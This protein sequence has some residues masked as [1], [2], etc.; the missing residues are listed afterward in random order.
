MYKIKYFKYKKKYIKLRDLYAGADDK[1]SLNPKALEWSPTTVINEKKGINTKALEWSPNTV[2]KE[3]LERAVEKLLDDQILDHMIMVKE[4]KHNDSNIFLVNL[5]IAQKDK[6][7]I[8]KTNENYKMIAYLRNFNNLHY[9][10]DMNV[11]LTA[12][13]KKRKCPFKGIP[14]V[15]TSLKH[16]GIRS[17]S[18]NKYSVILY[19]ESDND[20]KLRISNIISLLLTELKKIENTQVLICL[21]EINP[22]NLFNEVYNSLNTDGF[23][24]IYE[25]DENQGTQ[26]ILIYSN[27]Y[28]KIKSIELD[29]SS[30]SLIAKLKTG[31]K[32]F[33]NNKYT[34]EFNNEIPSIHLYNVHTKYYENMNAVNFVCTLPIDSN[35]II[36]GDMNLRIEDNEKDMIIKHLKSKNINIDFTITPE[37][38]FENIETNATYDIIISTL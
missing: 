29:S 11:R 30:N 19:E 5:N 7:A 33:Q 3:T 10:T 26:S 24:I 16:I 13:Q 34:I 35:T 37:V 9:V 8:Y 38:H 23:N 15:N 14:D 28:E 4:F 17:T 18:Q 6:I 32:P 12:I 2:I 1:H 20:Y 25:N 27:N 36:V 31:K 22:I 21:Q